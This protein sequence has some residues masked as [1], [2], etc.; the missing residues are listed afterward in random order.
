MAVGGRWYGGN[1]AWAARLSAGGYRLADAAKDLATN[2]GR[3]SKKRW[4]GGFE[5]DSI[6]P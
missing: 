6:S 3:M 4:N 1:Y 2:F 5:Y